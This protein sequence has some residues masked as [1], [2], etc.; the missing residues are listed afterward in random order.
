[1]KVLF[2]SSELLMMFTFL[3]WFLFLLHVST[4][5]WTKES[6]HVVEPWRKRQK[7]F[8]L[9]T[10]MEKICDST[11][12]ILLFNEPVV[13]FFLFP[14]LLVPVSFFFLSVVFNSFNN[15]FL[16]SPISPTLKNWLQSSQLTQI[17]VIRKCQCV[18]G[19]GPLYMSRLE[20]FVLS[21]VPTDSSTI[22]LYVPYGEWKQGRM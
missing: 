4:A 12:V 13:L 21:L 3:V 1:M 9:F 7:M 8:H 11:D 14:P 20:A 19:P 2:V 6:S 5:R 16:F 22:A 15:F 18:V 17:C 10:L